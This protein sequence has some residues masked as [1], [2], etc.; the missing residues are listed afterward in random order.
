MKQTFLSKLARAALL[1]AALPMLAPA[2]FPDR[3]TQ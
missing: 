1:L 3:T 2:E